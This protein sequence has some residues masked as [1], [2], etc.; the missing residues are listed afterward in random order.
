M[1]P[2][3][4]QF[5]VPRVETARLI[6][7]APEAAD[8]EAHAAFIASDRSRFVGGPQPRE[9]AWRGFCGSIGHWA[10]RG[11]G[12]WV[13]TGKDGTAPLGRVGFINN[14][15]WDEPE[16]AWHVYADAEGKGIAFE[17]ALAARSFGARHFGLDGVMSPI[18]PANTRS[19]K[20]AE[21]L[22][23]RFE[24]DGELMGKPCQIW[25]HPKQREAA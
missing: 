7:R 9:D 15:G 1:T 2:A 11:Y 19:L 17:A 24:R 16:L 18:D 20:L 4:V 5:T 23:A 13:I 12:M 21:R 14:E 22:G 8:F 6:L 25:R 3:A 10:V